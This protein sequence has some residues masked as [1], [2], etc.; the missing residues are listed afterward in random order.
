[1]LYP[2]FNDVLAA[3]AALARAVR[4]GEET[5]ALRVAATDAGNILTRQL[6]ALDRNRN[7]LAGDVRTP[8]KDRAGAAPAASNAAPL[9]E[10]QSLRRGV[11][12]LVEVGK[13]VSFTASR[14]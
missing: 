14:A 12:A 1:M 5:D 2:A 6:R 10:M 7:K 13:L 11:L 4:E 8:R 3:R 9:R